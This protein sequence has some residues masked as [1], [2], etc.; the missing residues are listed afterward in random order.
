MS[1]FYPDS[2]VDVK[3][4]IQTS[5]SISRI[6]FPTSIHKSR[7]DIPITGEEIRR[8][9]ADGSRNPHYYYKCRNTGKDGHPNV[10]WRQED[11]ETRV[12]RNLES[13]R[14]NV[15]V[16]AWFRDALGEGFRDEEVMR[17]E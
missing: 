1:S 4:K 6:R 10:R 16:A 17:E 12:V 8:R 13:M 5:G 2:R 3:P 9:L 7:G 14:L 15:N 11:L